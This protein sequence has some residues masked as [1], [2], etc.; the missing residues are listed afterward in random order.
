MTDPAPG[1]RS[2]EA[3][4]DPAARLRSLQRRLRREKRV[5]ERL[6]PLEEPERYESLFT[7]V[8]D[9]EVQ[10]RALREVV[11]PE[12]DEPDEPDRD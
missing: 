8:I 9:L 5:L 1:P 11:G 3:G 6:N 4:D 12:G 2:S 10:R 7:R